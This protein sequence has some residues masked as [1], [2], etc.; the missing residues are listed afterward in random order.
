MKTTGMGRPRGYTLV[1]LL[2]V[3]LIIG[4]VS[5][6]TLPTVLPAISH[7]QVSESARILQAA[8][9]GARDAAIRADAPR[10]IRLLPDPAFPGS[11]TAENTPLAF[12]RIVPIEPAGEYDEGRVSIRPGPGPT[13]AGPA[14]RIEESQVSPGGQAN[15]RTSWYWNV[16]VGDRIRIGASGHF[17]TVVGPVVDD[18]PERF[19]NVGPPGPPVT[20][21]AWASV[22]EPGSDVL[23]VV[24]GHDDNR[25]GL[26]DEGFDGVDNDGDGA[27]DEANED[28]G[29]DNNGDGT[30]DDPAER[31]TESWLGQQAM[32]P[33]IDQPYTIRRRPYPS[34]GARAVELPSDVVIDATTWDSTRERSRLPIDSGTL[35]VDIMVGPDGQIVPNTPYSSPAASDLPFYHLWLGER[36]D[37]MDPRGTGTTATRR[38]PVPEGTPGL[39]ATETRSLK[40]DRRLVT[41][42][43]RTG[44]IVTNE[45]ESFDPANVDRPF[46][47]AQ[48]GTREA[49]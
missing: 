43:T 29:L 15:A 24:N 46:Y 44:Q 18:N 40:G 27:A 31:E 42:F 34:P 22:G 9:E 33:T 3:I 35:T 17:Y 28:D 25:N 39:P 12:N 47:D 37:V 36:G 16:R 26:I 23:F 13:I 49:R 11:A 10:G 14:L 19:V 32:F 1:E 30:V 7:R 5:A 38:L 2:V 45:V 8:I 41:V 48:M 20:S 4:V 21:G 6:A